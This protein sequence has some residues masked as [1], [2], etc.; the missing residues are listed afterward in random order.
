MLR[1]IL[2]SPTRYQK[3]IYY[4]DQGQFERAKCSVSTEEIL[5]I[6]RIVSRQPTQAY[7]GKIIHGRHF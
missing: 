3:Q 7:F 1:Q 6:Y 4:S 2:I 5:E